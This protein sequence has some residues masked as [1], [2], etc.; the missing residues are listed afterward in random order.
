MRKVTTEIHI[1]DL[2]ARNSRVEL[3]EGEIYKGVRINLRYRF[4]KCG[5]EI[6]YS[7]RNIFTKICE[8]CLPIERSKQYIDN[9][10][11]EGIELLPNQTYINSKTKLYYKFIKCGHI[12][13]ITPNSIQQDVRCGVC[14]NNT[15]R[16]MEQYIT[17]ISIL[18]PELE[19]LPNQIYYNNQTSILHRFKN[20]N[21]INS[22]TPANILFH[23]VGCK[24]CKNLNT[25][26]SLPTT[27]EIGYL[28]VIKLSSIKEEFIKVGVTTREVIR[29]YR[30]I[31][32]NSKYLVQ[33]ISL[34]KGIP[35]FIE[36]IE[37]SI[38]YRYTKYIP[39][40]K[41]PGYTEC[42]KIDY[43][44]QILETLDK[45]FVC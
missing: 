35:E 23:K 43:L 36:S 39:S 37:K 2:K 32:L 41:F 1:Q 27:K 5:H 11:I 9:F 44:K 3:V 7:P 12:S 15:K 16:T 20:C 13:Y 26:Y 21:H 28:Y 19:V 14:A 25:R 31:E 6:T 10:S 30:E 40:V 45:E 18:R 29:R 17:E 22:C 34:Y 38:H 8:I 42:F 24:I 4:V 33:E